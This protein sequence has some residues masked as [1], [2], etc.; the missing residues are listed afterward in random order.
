MVKT[1]PTNGDANG[2]Y[3]VTL[4]DVIIMAR[5]LAGWKENGLND[6]VDANLLDVNNDKKHNLKDLVLIAQKLQITLHQ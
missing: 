1:N 2:D 6:I 3:D 5:A 4:E